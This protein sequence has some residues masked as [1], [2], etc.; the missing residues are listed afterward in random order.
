MGPPTD[1]SDCSICCNYIL[2]L[3]VAACGQSYEHNA[4]SCYGDG[5]HSGKKIPVCLMFIV[6]MLLSLLQHLV[7]VDAINFHRDPGV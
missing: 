7:I 1:Q 3:H 6:G 2:S 5:L 4:I